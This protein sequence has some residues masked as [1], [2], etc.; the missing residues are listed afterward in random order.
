MLK[1]VFLDRDGVINEKKDDYVKNLNELKILP[2]VAKAIKKL[3]E[4]NYLVIIIT[5]QSQVNR[6][7]ISE[8]DLHEINDFIIQKMEREG[9]KITSVYYCPH[10]P[11]ENC[12]CRKPRPGLILKAMNEFNVDPSKCILIGDSESDLQAALEAKITGFK[13]KTNGDLLAFI[14]KN[15]T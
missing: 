13:M 14:D 8:N 9:A 1:V 7:I 15:I 10:T 6:N 4:L 12:F 2:N 3:N 11:T 5:N